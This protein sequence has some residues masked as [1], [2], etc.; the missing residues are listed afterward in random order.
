MKTFK[1]THVLGAV[2]VFNEET[3]PNWLKYG[4]VK[5]STLDN[6]WFWDKHVMMLEVGQSVST[7]FSVIERLI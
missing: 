6:R 7:D 2:S 3:T 1:I 4:G 5:G